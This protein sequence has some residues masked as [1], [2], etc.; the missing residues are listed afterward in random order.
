MPSDQIQV[1][2]KLNAVGEVCPWPVILTLKEIKKLSPG[3][4]LEVLTDHV[5]S[6]TNIPEAVKKNGHE[7]V[8][9][10]Q[11]DKGLY[12]IVIRVR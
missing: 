11:I 6:V 2:R 4:I 5:P 9:A 1:D 12:R 10:S 8:D 7:I 3:Q